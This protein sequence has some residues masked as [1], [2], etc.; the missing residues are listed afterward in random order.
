[1][2]TDPLV[3]CM[4]GSGFNCHKAVDVTYALFS[5]RRYESDGTS[6]GYPVGRS[7]DGHDPAVR[8]TATAT[9]GSHT[10]ATAE[11]TTVHSTATGVQPSHASQLQCG[12]PTSLQ[13]GGIKVMCINVLAK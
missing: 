9:D 7:P 12:C 3:G 2:L 11:P 13:P 1:M 5:D 6:F 8:D 10:S 4:H